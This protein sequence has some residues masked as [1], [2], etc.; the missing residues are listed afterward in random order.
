MEKLMCKCCEYQW[1]PRSNQLPKCCPKCKSYQWDSEPAYK[2]YGFGDM[3]PGDEKY[4]KFKYDENSFP[5]ER[6]NQN[7]SRA[8]TSYQIRNPN[9]KFLSDTKNLGLLV[10]RIS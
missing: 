6:F 10:R 9:T 3:Q 7:I 4:F 8:L 2:T 1:H 5:D